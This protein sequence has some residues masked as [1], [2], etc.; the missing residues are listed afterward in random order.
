VIE[1]NVAG[2]DIGGFVKDAQ[3]AI[4]ASVKLP[5]GYYITW[6]VN[7]RTSNAPCTVS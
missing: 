5:L 2:R 1:C 3:R 6:A 4:D 7:L